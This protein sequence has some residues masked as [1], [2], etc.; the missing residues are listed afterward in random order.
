MKK[1]ILKGGYKLRIFKNGSAAYTWGHPW[2]MSTLFSSIDMTIHP[3]WDKSDLSEK[4]ET[5]TSHIQ[6]YTKLKSKPTSKK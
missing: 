4:I 6:N 3:I 5:K 2:K 1:T